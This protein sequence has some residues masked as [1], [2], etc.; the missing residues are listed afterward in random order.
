M[1]QILKIAAKQLNEKIQLC[2]SGASNECS[3]LPTTPEC[4]QPLVN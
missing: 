1:A 4:D 3:E 2:A